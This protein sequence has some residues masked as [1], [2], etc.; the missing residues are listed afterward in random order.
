[1]QVGWLVDSRDQPVPCRSNRHLP[2]EWP[3]GAS[4][5]RAM[6]I[7]TRSRVWSSLLSPWSTSAPR[8]W[9]FAAFF[10]STTRAPFT[11]KGTRAPA[12]LDDVKRA[13]HHEHHRGATAG[14]AY[15]GLGHYSDSPGMCKPS[16]W[17]PTNRRQA[18]VSSPGRLPTSSSACKFDRS[19]SAVPRAKSSA[20]RHSV[21]ASI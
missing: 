21:R 19:R 2:D 11:A 12:I 6:T 5:A 15:G 20:C 7:L 14:D 13:Q 17:S 9:T 4:I 8:R 1:M 18:D 3:P 16:S 10:F